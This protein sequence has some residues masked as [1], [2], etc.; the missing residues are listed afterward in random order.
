M[1]EEEEKKFIIRTYEKAELAHL[2]NPHMP[3]VSAM[4]KLRTWI[5]RNE[6]LTAAL[7]EAGAN[8]R[9]HSYPPRQVALIVSV[10][11]EP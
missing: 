10:L 11:G 6:Q 5:R 2:Y 1:K 9:D 3:L 8:Q 7:I 4:R